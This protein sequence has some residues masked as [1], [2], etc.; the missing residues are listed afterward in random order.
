MATITELRTE[1]GWRLVR[2]TIRQNRGD[3]VRVLL[4]SV[5]E[6]LP[7]LASGALVASALDFGFLRGDF[8]TGLSLL[9]LYAG[10]II[11]G[12]FGAR[13]SVLPLARIVES[14]RY[15]LISRTVRATLLRGLLPAERVDGRSVE[16]ATK[17]TEV[18]RMLIAQLLTVLRTAIFSLVFVIIGLFS[19]APTVAWVAVG[20]SVLVVAVLVA[21]AGGWQ[22]RIRDAL[23]AEEELSGSAGKALLGLRDV[24]AVGAMD[25]ATRDIAA[26]VDAHADAVNRIAR[27]VAGRVAI[28]ALGGRLPLA[29]LLVTAPAAISAHALTPGQLLGAATYLIGSLDPVLRAIVRVVGD[30][31]LQIGVLFARVQEYA[32]MPELEDVENVAKVPGRGLTLR[33]VDFAY[34]AA[35]E[36]ILDRVDLDIRPGE[37]LV[38]V[39]PSGAGKSTMANLLTG[40]DHPQ[41]GTISLDGVPVNQLDR[42]WLHRK[43]T[44]LPQEAYVFSGSVRENLSYLGPDV[45]GEAL[46]RACEAVGAE[47]LVRRLGGLDGR[48]DAPNELSEG[49]KQLVV[50]ARAYA[51]DAEIVVLDEA[52]CHLHPERERQVEDAFAGTGRTMIVIAHRMSSAMRADRVVLLHAGSPDVGTHHE[53]RES[54][55]LYADLVGYWNEA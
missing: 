40:L 35:S 2:E 27:V 32:R 17:H 31:G 22:R 3:L 49:Q 24:V 12:G 41:H 45:T 5:L 48:I 8:G 4:W 38:V 20:S 54:S 6:A 34:S 28:L 23:L 13:Q 36:K 42:A 16:G 33:S 29:V 1:S 44:L 15:D 50:L 14:L 10:V 52:T 26:D 18:L 9:L 43:I 51:S 39:G 55:P 37:R 19:L 21:T 46:K 11:L 7:T 30:I 47:E 25:R 53:L